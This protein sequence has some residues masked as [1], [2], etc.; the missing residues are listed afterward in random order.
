M[1]L[2]L[3]VAL[4]Q[5]PAPPAYKPLRYEEDWSVLRDPARRGDLFDPIKFIP[6]DAAG[7]AWL[8]LGADYRAQFEYYGEQ[9]FG[10]GPE[11]DGYLLQRFY[12]YADLHLGPAFR[13]FFMLKNAL[14]FDTQ[15]D[16]FPSQQNTID[17]HDAFVDL[18]LKSGDVAVTFRPGRQELLY[19]TG[20]LIDDRSGPNSKW[21]YDAARVIV[22][23]AGAFRVDALVGRPVQPDLHGFD[24][25]GN[26]DIAVWGL[27]ATLP[28]SGLDLYWLGIRREDWV[29][30]EGT[31]DAT[32]Q[33]FGARWF[34]TAYRDLDWNVEASVQ[35]GDFDGGRLLAWALN[36]DVGWIFKDLPAGP[37][38]GCRFDAHS[39]DREAGDGELE[40]F[41]P[42]F[43]RGILQGEAGSFG[44]PNLV[45]ATPEIVLV[46]GDWYVSARWSFYWRQSLDDGLYSLN[47]FPYAPAGTG[48]ERRIGR[49]LSLTLGRALGRHVYLY[50][51]FSYTET[52]PFLEDSGYLENQVFV[53]AT[54]SVRF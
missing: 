53:S 38:I 26:S 50:S 33:T 25:S 34:A 9:D 48:G 37:R 6:L 28:P 43:P 11:R 36:V 41:D 5:Q 40:T 49:E 21:T 31:G 45:A 3:L 47:L 18:A 42:F 12:P 20:R 2:L 10:T 1:S 13:A 14:A 32:R 19:G 35:T 52:G 17:V 23:Q 15:N 29:F 24:D 7:D 22:E 27:Y 16:P 44:P 54:V 30:E 4:A 8:T 46:P 51:V 39:G